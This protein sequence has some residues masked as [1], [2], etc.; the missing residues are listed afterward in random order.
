MGVRMFSYDIDIG[1][2]ED[3]MDLEN[4]VGRFHRTLIL[5]S[6]VVELRMV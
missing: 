3:V 5:D 1:P 2:I 6:R 4:G